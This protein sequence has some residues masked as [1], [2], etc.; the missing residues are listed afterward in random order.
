MEN[1]MVV[2]GTG[3]ERDRELLFNQCRVSVWGDKVLELDGED[4]CVTTKMY[5]MPLK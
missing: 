4:G 2:A 1:R 3:R 5:L